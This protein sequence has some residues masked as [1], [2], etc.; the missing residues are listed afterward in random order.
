M[1]SVEVETTFCS[2]F[3]VCINRWT[4]N[5]VRD[6]LSVVTTR[7]CIRQCGLAKNSHAVPS[8]GLT[9]TRKRV[10]RRLIR[11]ESHS[12]LNQYIKVPSIVCVA[13]CYLR[14]GCWLSTCLCTSFTFV[15]LLVRL[16]IQQ[17]KPCDRAETGKN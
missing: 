1:V 17:K 11:R 3:L 7:N 14:Q 16:G 4:V 6:I 2:Y 15:S 13:V 12:A 8:S 9:L 5:K 10:G